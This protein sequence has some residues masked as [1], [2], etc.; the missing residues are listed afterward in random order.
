MTRDIEERMSLLM[1][2]GCSVQRIALNMNQIED[3]SPPPNPA[4]L[5]D[6]RYSGY[7]KKHGS[8]SWELDALEPRVLRDLI[9][10]QVLIHRDENTLND[11]MQAETQYKKTLTEFANNWR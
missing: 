9:R 4:K 5:T 8:S 7:I 2:F 6:S 10:H 3:Y 11:I 1:D